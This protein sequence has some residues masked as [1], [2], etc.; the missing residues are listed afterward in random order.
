MRRK[1]GVRMARTEHECQWRWPSR[2]PNA[3][4]LICC[5]HLFTISEARL[6]E[7]ERRGRKGTGQ[8]AASAACSAHFEIHL[9]CAALN[10]GCCLP[11][12]FSASPLSLIL[13]CQNVNKCAQQM[14]VSAIG[15]HEGQRHWHSY[16]LRSVRI[17]TLSLKLSSFS[18]SLILTL[19]GQMN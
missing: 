19:H 14:R 1:H 16:L 9:T 17:P 11:Y 10:R 3:L 7:R 13:A 8:T 12:V 5:A 6:R 15:K 18:F 2:L 4:A